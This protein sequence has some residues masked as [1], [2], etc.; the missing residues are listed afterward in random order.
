MQE[1]GAAFDNLT[2]V[3]L[4]LCMDQIYPQLSDTEMKQAFFKL[5]YNIIL[6]RGKLFLSSPSPENF[7][8]V[9]KILGTFNQSFQLQDI[10]IFKQNVDALQ[11]LNEKQHLYQ[12]IFGTTLYLTEVKIHSNLAYVLKILL[13]ENL[14][15]CTSSKDSQPFERG[16]RECDLPNGGC[17]F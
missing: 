1:P 5:L 9:Q 4:T 7:E 11:A 17:Q 10:T 3:V 2:P 14:L 16:H 12:K 8:R 6:N 15:W 13:F